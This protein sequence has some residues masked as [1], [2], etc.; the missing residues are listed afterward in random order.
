MPNLHK[1]I[2]LAALTLCAAMLNGC[3]YFDVIECRE[4]SQ[5]MRQDQVRFYEYLAES[6]YLMG[7]EYFEI[8]RELSD[9][10][11]ALRSQQMAR[12]AKQ[13]QEMSRL[14]YTDADLLRKNYGMPERQASPA[15]EEALPDKMPAVEIAP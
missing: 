11:N 13:Y 4:I 15:G 3:A 1:I 5:Q 9:Q 8:S 7:Y 2:S 10:Q 12:R 6:Y 14:L